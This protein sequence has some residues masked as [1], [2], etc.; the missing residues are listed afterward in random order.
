MALKPEISL[1]IQP[2]GP[3]D[4]SQF[5]KLRN[6]ATQNEVMQQEIA[7]SK[8]Q[9]ANIEAQTPGL[10]EQSAQ[11]A[12]KTQEAQKAW[13]INQRITEANKAA[14]TVDANGKTTYDP[15][16]AF[17]ALVKQ[18]HGEAAWKV[19][20]DATTYAST[21]AKSNEEVAKVG[22]DF[23]TKTATMLSNVKDPAM[24][25]KVAEGIRTQV[26]N[27]P[28]LKNSAGASPLLQVLLQDP[29]LADTVKTGTIT[30]EKAIELQVNMINANANALQAAS[31][32]EH[33]K[34]SGMES[35]TGA[36]A[37]DPGTEFSKSYVKSA[38]DAKVPGV[39][40]GMSAYEASKLVGAAGAAVAVPVSGEVKARELELAGQRENAAK[41]YDAAAIAARK[42][43]IPSG[44]NIYSWISQ[45]LSKFGNDEEFKNLQ[46][47]VLAADPEGKL[48]LSAGSK[49]LEN[50]FINK[51][52]SERSGKKTHLSIAESSTYNEAAAK[53]A[54]DNP[55]P[56]PGI[57]G[58][59]DI[60]VERA[61][62]QAA[63]K[64]ARTPTQEKEI[65]QRF[66]DV[67]GQDL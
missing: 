58:G 33:V 17:D 63:L 9:Q 1:G 24:R 29:A 36:E 51:A 8:S 25:A 32:A 61:N 12:I 34:Q 46:A 27:N 6:L 16:K 15:N 5:A 54:K 13:E 50:I 23:A 30:P 2:P 47:A 41:V 44:V 10:R 21:A 3:I 31:Q 52:A 45:N 11:Q 64:K 7:A 37:R 59:A 48:S 4:F 35:L 56:Q 38:I 18:G 62:A 60:K 43:N 65:K 42:Y 14:T 22:N 66:K 40:P 28:V 39:T 19:L 67:T 55:P 53:I 49:G 20:T 57:K 26:D